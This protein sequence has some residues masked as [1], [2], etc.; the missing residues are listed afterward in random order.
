MDVFYKTLISTR[1]CGFIGYFYIYKQKFD[2]F[3]LSS[4]SAPCFNFFKFTNINE[5]LKFKIQKKS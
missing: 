4:R 3:Y 1:T 2:F 5:I